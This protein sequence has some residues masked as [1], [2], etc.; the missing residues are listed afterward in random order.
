MGGLVQRDAARHKRHE[1]VVEGPAVGLASLLQAL[2]RGLEHREVH[3]QRT[4]AHDR[5]HG[6][7]AGA[8]MRAADDVKSTLL[9]T[10]PTGSVTVPVTM[11]LAPPAMPL[12]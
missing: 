12:I 2:Q 9:L 4:A 10:V 7:D 6:V 11:F 5:T 3:A 1:R 8:R